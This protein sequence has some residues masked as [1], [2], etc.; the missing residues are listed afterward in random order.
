MALTSLFLLVASILPKSDTAF[1]YSLRQG[2]DDSCGYAVVASLLNIYSGM[3]VD[4]ATLHAEYGTVNEGEIS[5]ADMK[6]I[7][8][9]YGVSSRGYLM[10]IFE[11]AESLELVR[12]LVIHFAHPYRHF[13]LLLGRIDAGFVVADPANGLVLLA[14]EE[15]VTRVSGAVLVAS[16]HEE[17]SNA[18]CGAAV[19]AVQTRMAQLGTIDCFIH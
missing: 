14:F 17:M 16:V 10:D 1:T 3:L 6:M 15:F 13:A 18:L 2:Q 12:P 19:E 8:D 9:E 11:V 7:L 4:E 5:F